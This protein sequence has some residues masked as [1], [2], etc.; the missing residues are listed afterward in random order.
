MMQEEN[1]HIHIFHWHGGRK[2]RI[3]TTIEILFTSFIASFVGFAIYAL[4]GGVLEGT[5]ATHAV[6][7][8]A[9]MLHFIAAHIVHFSIW[10][11]LL[12]I[13]RPMHGGIRGACIFL[14]TL[15]WRYGELHRAG[16][17]DSF[18]TLPVL[19][20]LGIVTCSA[21]GMVGAALSRSMAISTHL[22]TIQELRDNERDFL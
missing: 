5:L 13:I 14:W 10:S 18:L 22:M 19:L 11:L 20:I 15:W 6:N 21:A 16:L 17:L 9:D 4:M 3:V 12:A 2:S 8:T 1:R 7:G